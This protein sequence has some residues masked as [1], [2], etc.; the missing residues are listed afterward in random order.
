MLPFLF[1]ETGFYFF[2]ATTE[3]SR[4]IS[5]EKKVHFFFQVLAEKT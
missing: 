1:D 2:S 4:D 5:T 3:K